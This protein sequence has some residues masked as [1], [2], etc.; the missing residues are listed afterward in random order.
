MM[1]IENFTDEIEGELEKRSI[2]G[3]H[4]TRKVTLSVLC[5]FAMTAVSIGLVVGALVTHRG[6]GRG[7]NNDD[8]PV[9]QAKG[10]SFGDADRYPAL[11]ELLEPLVGNVITKEG[12]PENN[13]LLWLANDDPRQLSLVTSI[14]KLTQRFALAALYMSTGGTQWDEEYQYNFLS[15]KDVCH[16]N[17]GDDLN[18]VYCDYG[19]GLVNWVELVDINLNGTLPA[20]IGLLTNLDHLGLEGNNLEGEIPESIGLLTKLTRMEMR[21]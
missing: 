17:Y 3:V 5:C 12:T 1:E 15:K 19:D 14:D 7:R 8:D 6:G 10:P 13:A 20:T 9:D 18:G 16:W 2:M 11:L 4:I 21:T